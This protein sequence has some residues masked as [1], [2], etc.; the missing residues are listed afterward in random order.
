[1]SYSKEC[2]ITV[3]QDE[4]FIE[5]AGEAHTQELLRDFKNLIIVR[6]FTKIYGI[7]GVRLGYLIADPHMR[8]RIARQLP[9]WNLSVFAQAAGVIYEKRP[10]WD[11]EK[12]L[13]E[14]VHGL[15]LKA[16]R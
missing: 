7:P 15:P 6:A 1:M 12:Y 2:G 14:R 9:E 11:A 13:A 16:G 3:V 10:D 8:A 4:C 5:F